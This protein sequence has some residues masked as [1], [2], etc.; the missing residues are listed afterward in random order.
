MNN[1]DVPTVLC[2][3]IYQSKIEE[4]RNLFQSGVDPNIPMGVQ[5]RTPLML[6]SELGNEELVKLILE[7]GGDT[8]AKDTGGNTALH[9]AVIMGHLNCIKLL[10]NSE[11]A[12]NSID[13]KGLTPMEWAIYKGRMDIINYMTESGINADKFQYLFGAFQP[14]RVLNETTNQNN[15][16]P[17]N[18][19]VKSNKPTEGSESQSKAKEVEKTQP[20]ESGGIYD[21]EV[22]ANDSQKSERVV[23]NPFQCQVCSRC[24]GNF[25]ELSIHLRTHPESNL[26]NR[27]SAFKPY[28]KAGPKM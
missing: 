24:Y 27:P 18:L 28:H 17:I 1:S 8:T 14:Y 15:L 11:V 26:F 23:E 20:L 2:K 9:L 10:F 3:L 22:S 5:R 19:S 12:E 6:A 13:V 25:A 21:L 4:V 16:I 7:H